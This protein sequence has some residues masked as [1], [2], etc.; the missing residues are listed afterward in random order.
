MLALMV[1]IACAA[2][3]PHPEWFF[4]RPHKLFTDDPFYQ[5]TIFRFYLLLFAGFAVGWLLQPVAATLTPSK[6]YAR[7]ERSICAAALLTLC[8]FL[9]AFIVLAGRWQFG[10]FDYNI[11][12]ETAWRQFL[13]QHPYTDFPTTAPPIFNIGAVLAL[14]LFG[15]SWDAT[16]WFTA[17][18]TCVTALWLYALLRTLAVRPA[19][20]MGTTLAI[21]TAAML[22]CS[23]WWYNN[24]T[25]VLAAVFLLSAL[26]ITRPRGSGVFVALSFTASVALLALGKP[27][28]AGL[29]LAAG[30]LV[31]LFASPSRRQVALLAA[32][33][34]ALS[35]LLLL[36]MHMSPLAMVHAYRGASRERGALSSFGFDEFSLGD[37]LANSAWFAAVCLPLLVVFRPMLAAWQNHQRAVAVRWLL[38]P[39]SALVAIYGLRGNGELRDVELTLVL[40]ALGVLAFAS[41]LSTPRLRRYT[42]AL[43]CGL[44]ASDV[45]TGI[46]RDRVYT[47][48]LHHFFEW[49]DRDNVIAAGPLR[50]MRVSRTFLDTNNEVTAA[51]KTNP[52]PFF[53]GT[54]VDYSY[55]V[56]SLPSPLGF[57][58]WWHP[59][60]A[61]ARADM[62]AIVDRW[63]AQHFA[64]MI[65]MRSDGGADY[66]Y[67]PASMLTELA[68]HYTRDDRYPHLSIYHR[69]P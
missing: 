25:N 27:N 55:M 21:E 7:H 26:A 60:T 61:F 36:V 50:H 37:K 33:G 43:L 48:G 49:T 69:K 38:F 12:I 56:Q 5:A 8:G 11:L 4:Q 30:L 13:G 66:T 52:G 2:L 22:S 17:L 51:V 68:T 53:F 67:Y 39:L 62:P 41:S 9:T 14:R 3:A 45:Y 47:I 44:I 35:L 29:T 46:A 64:T 1:G 20:A 16:L 32:A 6:A 65:F 24:S 63:K 42:V 18:F 28:I 10:G 58:A 40:A 34:F 54:R 23:F 15:V 19:A 59:G 57:P 31:T